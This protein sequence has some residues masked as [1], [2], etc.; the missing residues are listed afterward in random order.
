MI[1][2]ANKLEVMKGGW[3]KVPGCEPTSAITSPSLSVAFQE[4]CKSVIVKLEDAI[5]AIPGSSV[6]TSLN[7]K[8]QY[9]V[10]PYGPPPAHGCRDEMCTDWYKILRSI[11]VPTEEKDVG[12]EAGKPTDGFGYFSGIFTG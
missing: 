2:I 5:S 9:F 7:P 10:L 1:R 12:C 8:I 4:D 11:G 3:I 6:E